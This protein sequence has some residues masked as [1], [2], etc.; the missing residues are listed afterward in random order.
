MIELTLAE[1]A[2][3]VGGE[4]H[5]PPG[6]P[7]TLVTAPAF[8]DSRLVEPGGLFVA[9]AGEHV[10]GHEYAEKAVA[11]GAAA[12]LGSRATGVPTVVVEDAVAGLGKLARYVADRLTDTTVLAVTGSQGKTGTKDYLAQLLAAAGP[13][14]AT[15]GN[16]NNEIGVPL[17]VLRATTETRYLVVEM[18]A[19]GIG[20]LSYL[21]ELVPPDVS[22]VINV[23]TAHL[24]EFGSR[25][26][27]AV[28]KGELVEALTPEGVAVLN[29]DD[30]MTA[31]MATRTRGRVST[32]GGTPDATVSW[33]DASLDDLGR[34]RF[35][36]VHDG[37]TAEVALRL[38][39]EH[40][41]PNATAAATAAL[42]AGLPLAE[43]ATGLSAATAT[44]RWRMEIHE[45]GDNVVL[46]NDS[47]NANPT[48][49]A[50]AI[51][52][53]RA[54]GERRGTRTIAVLGEMKE[55]GAESDAEHAG[56]GRAAAEADVDH[57][58]VVGAPALPIADGADSEADWK[59]VATRVG[60]R[61]EALAWLRK[62]V[63]A[64]DVV[65]VKASRAAE[66][67]KVALSLIELGLVEER[68]T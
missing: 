19:R 11:A 40:Q 58:L 26:A 35:T 42:A 49:M 63:A 67:E 61:D 39:G 55:L 62:N 18:G 20:H 68:S 66:L 13:T 24:G 29:A 27:I 57:L 5:G 22:V 7:E 36:L 52:A 6:S 47:Y 56:V 14:V 32:F 17:T 10:D 31:A 51:D 53:L 43:I 60:T 23:G 12:V 54:V 8:V 44:S 33:R 59:G 28:A 50:A 16:F 3:A 46:I 45:L 21:C 64:G 25:E 48:S 15:A 41:V 2:A 37:Q 1:I 65:L 34:P 4:V 30:P 9:I 38:V